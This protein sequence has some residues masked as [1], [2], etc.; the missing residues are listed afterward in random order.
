M[1]TVMGTLTSYPGILSS[2]AGPFCM[3]GCPWG[4]GSSLG[5]H[6]AAVVRGPR[7]ITCQV[8]LFSRSWDLGLR[9]P[10]PLL[11]LALLMSLQSDEVC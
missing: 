8:F 6:E 11:F 4:C 9:V 10:Q 1:Q 3:G 2:A 5:S 7:P